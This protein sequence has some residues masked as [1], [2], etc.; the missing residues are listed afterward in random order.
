MSKNQHGFRAGYS[1]NTAINSFLN[2]TY[3][4][5]SKKEPTLI[6]YID[7]RKAFDTVNHN[8]LLSKLVDQFNFGIS[9]LN[10]IRSFLSNRHLT[11][12]FLGKKS[13]KYQV[14]AGVPQGSVLGPVL[15]SL[16]INDCSDVIRDANIVLYADDT[17][18]LDGGPDLANTVKNMEK[19]SVL[20]V[21]LVQTQ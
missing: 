15:F 20:H 1:I 4:N 2:I 3:N 12:N 9:S 10:W 19:K 7:L 16:M 11:S 6:S 5:V 14:T 17:A 8:V 13:N 21:T 18:V